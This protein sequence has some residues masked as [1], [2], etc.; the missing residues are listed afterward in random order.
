MLYQDN[1]F[2]SE[3]IT[4]PFSDEW[5]AKR[6]VA[7]AIKQLTEVLVTS[8]PDIEKMNAI[9]AELEDTA[10]DFR[11]SP[12]IFGRSDWAASG[13]HG[14][15][16]QISHELNPLAAGATQSLHPSIAGSTAIRHSQSAS[17]AGPM[18]GRLGV[19][20]VASWLLFLINSL[21]WPRRWAAS[22]A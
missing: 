9:A 12:R 3:E 14:S 16:G 5:A 19:C 1:P 10:A 8:S 7:D 4:P 21:A 15:F 18:K 17:V 11:K 13:E 20:M 6:R 22:Q 2:A